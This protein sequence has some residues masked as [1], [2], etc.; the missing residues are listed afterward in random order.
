[1]AE[2]IGADAVESASEEV[3]HESNIQYRH[4]SVTDKEV[5]SLCHLQ[6]SSKTFSPYI[7]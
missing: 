1:M 6:R 2:K 4:G 7:G 3:N 5:V